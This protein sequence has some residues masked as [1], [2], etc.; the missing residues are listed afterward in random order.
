MTATLPRGTSVAIHETKGDSV[1]VTGPGGDVWVSAGSVERLADREARE[2]RAEAV[3]GFAAQPGRA[4][5][6]CPILLAP[7]YGAARWGTLED[8]DDVDVI[9][10][11]HDF[12]GVRLAGTMLAF[13]P[14]RAIRL[15]PSAVGPA[16]GAPPGKGVAPEIQSLGVPDRGT[17][18]TP[19]PALAPPGEVSSFALP[20]SPSPGAV[21]A[22]P[23]AAL[24]EG[25]EVPVLVTRVDPQYPEQ[26][27]RLRVG[28]D[29][30]LRV[31]VEANGSI[32]RIEPVGSAPFGMTEA[33][34][35]AVRRW[36]YRPARVDGQPVAVWKVIRVKFALHAEREPPPD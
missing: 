33:A 12:F 27:R 11:D 19:I 1:R 6:P 14:A 36:T 4:V 29:V 2:A 26:A 5:E 9:L 13:V 8:G 35:D 15:L 22:A 34:V 3:K 10:A 20:A 24:P 30:V 18:P 25:S 7:D 28:G 16:P 21:A 32:G 23:L 31:V 17:L